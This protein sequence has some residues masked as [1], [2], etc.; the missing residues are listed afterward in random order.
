MIDEWWIYRDL[1]RNGSWLIDVIFRRFL[2]LTDENYEK[3]ESVFRRAFRD[4]NLAYYQLKP[5]ILPLRQSAPWYLYSRS[6]VP[7]PCSAGYEMKK[8]L[9][10]L[11]RIYQTTSTDSWFIQIMWLGLKRLLHASC[12]QGETTNTC[13]VLL[14]RLLGKYPFGKPRKGRMMQ[15]SAFWGD[16]IWAWDVDQSGS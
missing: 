14:R 1:K 10:T 13:K 16:S 15:L 5:I 2:G 7:S 12:G 8:L 4:S 9:H 6:S 11:T 3:H